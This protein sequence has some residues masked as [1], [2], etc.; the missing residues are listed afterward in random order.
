MCDKSLSISMRSL[1]TVHKS[2]ACC[3]KGHRLP[4][5]VL[6]QKATLPVSMRFVL[7]ACHIQY[8]LIGKTYLDGHFLKIPKHKLGLQGRLSNRFV[9]SFLQKYYVMYLVWPCNTKL[10]HF[11]HECMIFKLK[12]LGIYITW[13]SLYVWLFWYSKLAWALTWYSSALAMQ[14]SWV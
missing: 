2:I 14:S 7:H 4:S 13:P 1:L 5:P 3:R 9:C 11:Y 10:W 12:H 8:R 6:Q